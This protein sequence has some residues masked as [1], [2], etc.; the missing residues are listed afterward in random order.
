LRRKKVRKKSGSGWEAR[1]GP[2]GE[3][4]R[5]ENLRLNGE[6]ERK[7]TKEGEK[8]SSSWEGESNSSGKKERRE[9]LAAT[10][11]RRKTGSSK[12]A[13]RGKGGGGVN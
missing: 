13:V 2:R 9:K 6:I 1:V 8:R 10:S 11:T 7:K 4:L 5:R 12:A 3:R